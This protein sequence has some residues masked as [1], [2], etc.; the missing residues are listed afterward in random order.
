MAEDLFAAAF[1]A[2]AALLDHGYRQDEVG[3]ILGDN[4]QRVFRRV[5]GPSKTSR[6]L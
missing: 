5:G 2:H 6:A 3:K 1:E 4:A